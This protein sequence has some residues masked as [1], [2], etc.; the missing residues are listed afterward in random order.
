MSAKILFN[1]LETKLF[2]AARNVY[3]HAAPQESQS[4]KAAKEIVDEFQKKLGESTAPISDADLQKVHEEAVKKLDEKIHALRYPAPT[5]YSGVPFAGNNVEIPANFRDEYVKKLD[6]VKNKYITTRTVLEANRKAKEEAAKKQTL[7]SVTAQTNA[8]TVQASAPV[9]LTQKMDTNTPTATPAAAPVSM[10]TAPTSTPTSTPAPTETADKAKAK[11]DKVGDGALESKYETALKNQIN[12]LNESKANLQRLAAKQEGKKIVAPKEI[13]PLIA[14]VNTYLND[15]DLITGDFWKQ[16]G[17]GA[18]GGAVG[19]AALAAPTGAVIGSAVPFV[20]TAVGAGILGAGGLGV[21]GVIGGIEGGLSTLSNDMEWEGDFS[22]DEDDADEVVTNYK[23]DARSATA[24]FV[25]AMVKLGKSKAEITTA[26]RKAYIEGGKESGWGNQSIHLEGIAKSTGVDLNADYLKTKAPISMNDR[27]YVATLVNGAKEIFG[28]DPDTLKRYEQYVKG[29]LD[30]AEKQLKELNSIIEGGT[31]ED[32]ADAIN[33]QKSFVIAL[34][35]TPDAW[36]EAAGETRTPPM[37]KKIGAAKAK[38]YE[39]YLREDPG[40]WQEI[41]DANEKGKFKIDKDGNICKDD[42]GYYVFNKDT[43]KFVPINIVELEDPEKLMGDEEVPPLKIAGL[44]ESKSEGKASGAPVEPQETDAEKELKATEKKNMLAGITDAW[45]V[46]TTF[47][48]TLYPADQFPV[49]DDKT[50]YGYRKVGEQIQR[51]TDGGKT[52]VVYNFGTNKFESPTSSNAP[53]EP[54]TTGTSGNVENGST[55]G[56]EHSNEKS[57]EDIRNG[58]EKESKKGEF[59]KYKNKFYEYNKETGEIKFE[60]DQCE[61][62]LRLCDICKCICPEIMKEGG[63][64]IVEKEGGKK[65]EAKWNE[66]RKDFIDENEKHVTIFGGEKFKVKEEKAPEKDEEDKK[67]KAE[68]APEKVLTEEEQIDKMMK[69]TFQDSLQEWLE[70][71]IHGEVDEE[72]T[73]DAKRLFIGEAIGAVGEGNNVSNELVKFT[74]DRF[75]KKHLSATEENVIKGLREVSTIKLDDKNYDIKLADES[76]VESVVNGHIV[77][78][79]GKRSAAEKAMTAVL[80]EYKKVNIN[81][82]LKDVP[83]NLRA[84]A[85]EGIKDFIKE[86]LNDISGKLEKIKGKYVEVVMA[87]LL[88]KQYDDAKN[89]IK[90]RLEL[91]AKQYKPEEAKAPAPAY[92]AENATESADKVK[93]EQVVARLKKETKDPDLLASYLTEIPKNGDKVAK[94]LEHAVNEKIKELSSDKVVAI[95]VEPEKFAVEFMKGVV[96]VYE[97]NP[98]KIEEDYAKLNS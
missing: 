8:P 91:V 71:K 82:Y 46:P 86:D 69:Q 93:M 30:S 20:G 44:G 27:F 72:N 21:G 55:G 76:S 15:T 68:K 24:G 75:S 77:Y 78:L 7:T 2:K 32:Q 66:S 47:D 11:T 45:S 42:D 50:T 39:F 83:E 51:T 36:K 14:Q 38:L 53:V 17:M 37:D 74:S 29:R 16:V 84:K 58:L 81:D 60:N 18:A 64:L 79:E 54:G 92:K 13:D 63:C 52:C 25:L 23:N 5:P 22:A 97:N 35:D 85:E 28:D 62:S 41:P 73:S 89:Y 3:E 1:Q 4:Q 6:D 88:V 12:K 9:V 56:G 40:R 65:I 19:G 70:I 26:L 80:D 31:E 95:G 49:S 98:D 59:D 61:L 87:N 94:I 43:N 33:R 96:K 34:I 90:D 67:P 10:V 57:R 48:R